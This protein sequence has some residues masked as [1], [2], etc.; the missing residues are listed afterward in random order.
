[1]TQSA[2]EYFLAQQVEEFIDSEG[3]DKLLEL[4]GDI[5]HQKGQHLRENWQDVTTAKLW[6]RAGAKV[7]GMATN[8]QVQDVSGY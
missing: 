7:S 1:M 6:E 2:S 3:L 5:C 4:I 8:R